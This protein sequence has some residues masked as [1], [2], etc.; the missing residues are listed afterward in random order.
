[1]PMLEA[2]RAYLDLLDNPPETKQARLIALAEALDRLSI[3]YHQ[4]PDVE[5]ESDRVSAP[6][7]SLSYR[8]KHAL[9][10]P[11]FPEL[12]S[13]ASIVSGPPDKL[14]GVVG[15]AIDDLVDISGDLKAVLWLSENVGLNDAM[16]EFR[17]GYLI[18]WGQHL[19][20]LRSHIHYL[21]CQELI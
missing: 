10:G 16:W 13:Y 12:G 14:D 9:L 5:I 4:T 2:I 3:A 18:H 15:D 8:E 21:M 20:A 19:M 11:R 17:L 7:D 1:M 6:N